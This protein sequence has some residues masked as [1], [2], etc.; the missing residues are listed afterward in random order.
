MSTPLEVRPTIYKG[1]QMRSRLEAAYARHLD[2]IGVAW[3][4]EPICFADERG[5]YL[6]DFLVPASEADSCPNDLYIEVKP[7][8]L[9]YSTLN[10]ALRR[11]E[12]I[13]STDPKAELRLEQ[14]CGYP[15]GFTV[16]FT[17]HGAGD[18]QWRLYTSQSPTDHLVWPA[19]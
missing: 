6:P 9:S 2:S 8:G 5:Q 7:E 3:T 4:H 18:R 11:M 1:I 19:I 14:G 16:W 12:I 15:V 13:W 17:N 10:D